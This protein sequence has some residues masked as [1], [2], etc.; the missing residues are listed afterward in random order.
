M[1]PSNIDSLVDNL[2]EAHVAPLLRNAGI[3][4]SH[5]PWRDFVNLASASMHTGALGLRAKPILRNMVQSTFDWVFYGTKSYLKASANFMTAE[6]QKI[7]KKSLVWQ[8][9]VP[10]EAQDLATLQKIFKVGSIGYRYADLH[11]VGKGLLTRYYHATSELGMNPDEAI[12]WADTDLPATQ[13]SYRREDLPRLYW[14]SSGRALGTL[15]SWW[16]NF[17]F[18][19]LPEI[20]NRSFPL[21]SQLKMMCQQTE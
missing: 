10:F 12:K 8:T 6:G 11:N 7:L 19:F 13:W 1:R 17:Y 4:V 9:R 5:M 21:A 18:R 3:R 20:F 15:G 2:L 14:T 16:Q